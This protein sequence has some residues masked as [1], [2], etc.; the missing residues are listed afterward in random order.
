MSD[1]SEIRRKSLEELEA[2]FA[3]VMDNKVLTDTTRH[4][5]DNDGAPFD[6]VEIERRAKKY[7]PEMREIMRTMFGE[8]Q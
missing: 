5:P 2:E 8:I 6:E 1:T 4:V 7:A 3:D